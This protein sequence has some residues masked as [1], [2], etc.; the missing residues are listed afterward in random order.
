MPG[1]IR[2]GRVKIHLGAINNIFK[3]NVSHPRGF[4]INGVAL[5]G[6]PLYFPAHGDIMK[7]IIISRNI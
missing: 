6:D 1:V 5:Y 4:T 3:T 2:M 7:I